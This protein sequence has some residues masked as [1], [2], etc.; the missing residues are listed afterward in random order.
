M[1]TLLIQSLICSGQT[2]YPQ[3]FNVAQ[4]LIVPWVSKFKKSSLKCVPN[5]ER[6]TPSYQENKWI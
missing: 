5:N 4:I 3:W 6:Y 2:V 1:E